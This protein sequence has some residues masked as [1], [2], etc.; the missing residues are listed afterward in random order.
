MKLIVEI[1]SDSY[2]SQEIEWTLM[3]SLKPFDDSNRTWQNSATSSNW[4][5]ANS[6]LAT[7][8]RPIHGLA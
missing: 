3:N 8:I 7:E 2:I 6:G 5:S 1:H 4:V